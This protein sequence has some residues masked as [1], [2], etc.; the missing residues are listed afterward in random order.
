[1]TQFNQVT[2]P[3][4]V[5]KRSQGMLMTMT[6]LTLTRLIVSH[7]TTFMKYRTMRP[8]EQRYV[9]PPRQ[10]E[11]P[12]YHS[13]MKY[14][15]SKEPYLRPTRWCDPRE[16]EVIAMANELGAYELA[17]RDFAEA[18]FWFVKEN[19]DFEM[20]PFDGV[21][22]TLRRGTGT[23]YHNISL[24]IALCRA[25]GIKGRYKLFAINY[26]RASRGIEEE[27]K[28]RGIEEPS[29][30]DVVWDGLYNSL[31][32]LMSEA[33]AEVYLDSTWVVAHPVLTPQ[34]QA[35]T[36]IPITQLGEDSIGLFFD[37][38]PGTIQRSES[39]PL[40]LASGMRLLFTVMPGSPERVSVSQ[41]NAG[42]YGH[43][44]IEQAGG[45]EAYDQRARERFQFFPRT[46]DPEDRTALVFED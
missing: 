42:V 10:Y 40:G 19:I 41:M 23:C 17:D 33:E 30:I 8:D 44:V 9:R 6:G 37:V 2:E 21:G 25:A 18:A 20:C 14:S 12:E 27:K 16:P 1:V 4:T 36:G 28:R 7:P 46:V 45:R 32:Y 38:V 34:L 24:F 5:T 11:L 35:A 29:G 31:G 43:H 26:D 39:I 15:T 13:D 3:E 22:A